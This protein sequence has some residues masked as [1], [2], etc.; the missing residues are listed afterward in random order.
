[1]KW[2]YSGKIENIFYEKWTYEDY[3]MKLAK[4]SLNIRKQ[5]IFQ[6]YGLLEKEPTILC[7]PPGLTRCLPLIP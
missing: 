7:S 3:T 5:R 4:K 2:G 1:M 6:N